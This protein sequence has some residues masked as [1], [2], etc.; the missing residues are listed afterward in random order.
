MYR[1]GMASWILNSLNRLRFSILGCAKD[2]GLGSI[3]VVQFR[4]F[5]IAQRKFQ[6]AEVGMVVVIEREGDIQSI[7]GKQLSFLDALGHPPTQGI[8]GDRHPRAR[9]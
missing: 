5:E 7:A 8:V 9:I 4:T 2:H 6:S 1:F 3:S